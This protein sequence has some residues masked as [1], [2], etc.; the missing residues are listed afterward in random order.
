MFLDLAF[1]IVDRGSWIHQYLGS[2]GLYLSE[3]ATAYTYA[4]TV[5]A[6]CAL[7]VLAAR[8]LY[9]QGSWIHQYLGSHGLY[10]GEVATAYTYAYT[11]R[12]LCAV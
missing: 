9:W 10:L 11:V 8:C 6:L 2:Y 1:E 7:D 4:N 12:W 3:V 5:E